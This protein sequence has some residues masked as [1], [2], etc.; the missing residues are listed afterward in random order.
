MRLQAD[1]SLSLYFFS[2]WDNFPSSLFECLAGSAQL[3]LSTLRGPNRP[4][5]NEIRAELTRSEL[6]L[7]HELDTPK[8]GM[9]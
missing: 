8:L 4:K 1:N 7:Y 9:G 3:A 5:E 2:C 6:S